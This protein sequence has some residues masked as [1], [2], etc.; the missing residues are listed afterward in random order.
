MSIFKSTVKPWVAAQLKAREKIIGQVGDNNIAGVGERS[1]EFLR[2]VAGRNS[3]VRMIS[4]VNY[5]SQTF[6]AKKDGVGKYEDDGKYTG[7]FLSKKYVL[8][9]GTLY[10][11]DS[12]FSL[13]R[14]V[15]RADGIYGS[16]ID[17]VSSN[18]NDKKV[19]RAYGLRPM[20]GINSVQ[21]NNKSAY[22][23][24]REATVS[25]YAWDKH[26][27]EELEVLFM[28]PGYSVFLDWGWNTYL[29]HNPAGNKGINSYPDNIS[30]KNFDVLTPD[31]FSE[32]KETTIYS[33][34]DNVVEK[35]LG[36]YDAMLGY[37]KNFSWQLMGNGG[38]QCTTTLISRGE[39]LEGIKASN[40]PRTIIGSPTPSGLGN[41]DDAKPVFSFFEKIFLTIKGVINKSEFSSFNQPK[42]TEPAEG[43]D[44]AATTTPTPAPTNTAEYYDANANMQTIIDSVD[45]KWTTIKK[46]LEEDTFIYEVYDDAKG[47]Y[48]AKGFPVPTYIG[49][50][51]PTQG[52]ADGSGIEYISMNVFIAILQ[53]FFIP[54]DKTT[55]EPLVRIIIPY[56]TPC[57]MSEDT[58]SIDPTTCL[59]TNGYA[60]F[61]MDNE[62][63]NPTGFVPVIY[64]GLGFQESSQT[65]VPGNQRQMATFVKESANHPK[66]RTASVP[67][68][69]DKTKTKDISYNIVNVGEIGNVYI[70]VGKIIQT[71]RDMAGGE[72]GV[73]IVDFL[74][75]ILDDI[76]YSLGGI[77]DFKLYTDKNK[78]QII[79]TKYLEGTNDPDGG[80][81]QKFQLDLIGL[82]SICRDVQIT[83]KIFA[84]Q[85]T[86]IGIAAGSPSGDANNLGDVYSS[87]Q[88]LL[89][90]GLKDRV[91]RDLEY[92]SNSG[93]GTV[94][95]GSTDVS[96]ENLYYMDVYNNIISLTNYLKHKV[97]GSSNATNLGYYSIT[98]PD[99]SEIQ[100][101]A[102]LLKSL[103]YQLNG[104]DVDFKALIPFELEITL[105][106]IA[107]L[108]VGQIFTI[109]KDFLPRDYYNKNLGFVITGL[110]H[111]LQNNDWTTN[112]KTQICL[113][114]NERYAPNVDKLNL[115][116]AIT[117]IK[118]AM[119]TAAYVHYAMTDY[120][121]YLT[122]LI[123]APGKKKP[124]MEGNKEM[125]ADI[126]T[127]L[128][129]SSNNLT[130]DNWNDSYK[131]LVA[132]V[133][134][135][136][137][138]FD[139]GL[140]DT[141][142]YLYKWWNKN[143]G[144]GLKD[145]PQ[146]FEEFYKIKLPFDNQEIEIASLT[147]P[148][149]TTFVYNASKV[150]TSATGDIIVTSDFGKDD[151]FLTRFFGEAGSVRAY[152]DAN[153]VL[154]TPESGY[155]F[156]LDI[157]ELQK[158]WAQI[159]VRLDSDFTQKS[160]YKIFVN[161][162]AVE[163]NSLE[164]EQ[165]KTA[166]DQA[167]YD[168]L[169]K[170]IK[171]HS[172]FT[173]PAFRL[174]NALQEILNVN[175]APIY[176]NDYI[177]HNVIAYRTT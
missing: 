119:N 152:M 92:S 57:L 169:L 63:E 173:C 170:L 143:K 106:G 101:A 5:N 10:N 87:T 99:E 139:G 72:N 157:I 115:K 65:F 93:T 177:Q 88:N 3:F 49:G 171:E 107:G 9:G 160:N 166:A 82:K 133:I 36:N 45:D 98:A 123:T 127:F 145:F 51:L 140:S 136:A 39:V 146:T 161:A 42:K 64:T 26:Q 167:A 1:N 124:F 164:S 38:F 108:V 19:D 80:S 20:P 14:G 91:I 94:S 114:D 118:K 116:Q 141:N 35:N 84:E 104:K 134:K 168:N 58:V 148:F 28:R 135:N 86:M 81:S 16:N 53:R 31:V 21:I 111:T 175:V 129:A 55:F 163:M 112:V 90:K 144:S 155:Y 12:T 2:Y 46:A 110:S 151:F 30:V 154:T 126:T 15:N 69:N 66:S 70:A 85:S 7:N 41:P 44:P 109:T 78:V 176:I 11:N 156:W 22:G 153:F 125:Q 75:K 96:S 68:L 18:P 17:N 71:Y 162:R 54:R 128:D 113:L 117:A 40:N 52:T 120:L 132:T 59:I 77:N 73:N 56:E 97:I 32:L 100:N 27:L 138:R 33:S 4:M 105:D 159:L 130:R 165:V 95:I 48:T 43:A 67:D 37:V 60:T 137:I 142:S 74:Q 25:F 172:C 121:V 6:K 83:S 47:S 29:N 61:V 24:L 150:K 102:S 79:D 103:H 62:G 131:N 174:P 158:L 149:E 147:T 23:S 34:I 89:N 122:L 8:E 50:V 13:R 76:S